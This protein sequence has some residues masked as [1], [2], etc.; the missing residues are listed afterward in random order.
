MRICVAI[1]ACL[2]T[3]S[4]IGDEERKP[5]ERM[6]RAELEAYAHELEAE[7]ERLQNEV[8]AEIVKLKNELAGVKN[9]N[10]NLRAAKEADTAIAKMQLQKNQ[11]AEYLGEHIGVRLTKK[12]FR[13]A[14]FLRGDAGDIITL[15]LVFQ[16]KLPKDV[17]AFKGSIIIEDLFGDRI[18]GFGIKVDDPIKSGDYVEWR[19]GLDYNQF[20][21]EDRALRGAE[22]SEIK[23]TMRVETVIYDDGSV[24]NLE[25]P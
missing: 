20:D 9:E 2:L 6:P 15:E 17:R 23:A 18:Q 22:L 10:A 19:G 13:E 11:E 4:A 24:E 3:I 12:S 8:D 5:I 21:D 7:I 1:L 25:A 14:D 16:N